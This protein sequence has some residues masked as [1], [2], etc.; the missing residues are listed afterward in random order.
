MYGDRMAHDRDSKPKTQY[1]GEL[2]KGAARRVQS[3]QVDFQ[4]NPLDGDGI[5][6]SWSD[7]LHLCR[8]LVVG[9]TETPYQYGFYFFEVKYPNT[10]PWEAPLVK[11]LTGDG[12]VRLNPNLYVNGKVCLSI[13]GTW[14]GPPWTPGLTLR[15]VLI[16]IQS[17]LHA[18]PLQ[19]EPAFSEETGEKEERYARILTYEN[20]AV[21]VLRMLEHTPEGF[22]EF[23]PHLAYYFLR[24]L[25]VLKEVVGC[26]DARQG[27]QE[28]SP[29]GGF[30]TK[31]NAAKCIE[32]AD[33]WA[34]KI[35]RD[36]DLMAQVRA[37]ESD[38]QTK[39]R[40]LPLIFGLCA[41]DEGAEFAADWDLPALADCE[42]GAPVAV[43][44]V[45]PA[46]PPTAAKP[47]PSADTPPP[48]GRGRGL[49]SFCRCI[50]ARSA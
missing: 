9:P 13:L 37:L 48:K 19:N 12:R 39:V 22:D 16:S 7:E 24:F 41:G 35:R 46:A 49:A 40:D 4:K 18:H 45:E 14:S 44:L 21:S 31:Y 11:F 29:L 1:D 17:L 5:F 30:T 50:R 42:S 3:E 25:D 38:M 6:V 32:Q 8:A 15:T 2:T 10:Y 28:Q 23:K 43:E 26:F 47:E 34:N 20:V 33:I 27:Q 36:G